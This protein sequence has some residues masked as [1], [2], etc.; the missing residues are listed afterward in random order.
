M[1]AVSVPDITVPPR[2][3]E[4]DPQVARQRPVRSVTTA[5]KGYEGEGFHTRFGSSENTQVVAQIVE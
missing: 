4:P 3:P 1:P 5:P 2:L